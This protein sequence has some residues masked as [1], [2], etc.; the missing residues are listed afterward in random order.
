M[1]SVS[2]ASVVASRRAAC[3]RF[4]LVL[5]RARP[6]ITNTP[7]RHFC[8]FASQPRVSTSVR[9][10]IAHI[11]D[12]SPPRC[13]AATGSAANSSRGWTVRRF[14][15]SNERSSLTRV[16]AA[17]PFS[18]LERADTIA[19]QGASEEFSKSH[20]TPFTCSSAL[21][22]SSA[23]RWRPR[24]EGGDNCGRRPCTT[25]LLYTLCTCMHM[26][27]GLICAPS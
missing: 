23:S 18:W 6:E 12:T 21:D 9:H 14:G 26:I 25:S 7:T 19:A 5:A 16:A 8:H 15:W 13:D 10:C 27:A 20:P 22:S 17:E 1:L 2:L 4:R 3:S 11:A 24:Q